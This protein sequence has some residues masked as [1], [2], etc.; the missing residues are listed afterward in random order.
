MSGHKNNSA[1][2]STG[3]LGNPCVCVCVCVC[4]L[5][6]ILRQRWE[7]VDVFT[8]VL[9]AGHAE[10]E[11]KVKTLEQLLSEIMS[12]DHPEVF[13]RHVSHR[14]LHAGGTKRDKTDRKRG[15][16]RRNHSQQNKGRAR[17]HSNQS[18][19]NCILVNK[20]SHTFSLTWLQLAAVGEKRG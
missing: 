3:S 2:K 15:L 17:G 9:A 6:A 13:Y 5:T 7:F 14:E 19:G 16:R 11:L 8:G 1:V 12:L 20:D 4:G 10:A 18:V